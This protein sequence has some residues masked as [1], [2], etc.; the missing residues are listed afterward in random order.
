MF[1][2]LFYKNRY[3]VSRQHRNRAQGEP[4][5]SVVRTW[6]CRRTLYFLCSLC[7]DHHMEQQRR[8][9]GDHQETAHQQRAVEKFHRPAAD[10]WEKVSSSIFT[11]RPVCTQLK[12]VVSHRGASSESWVC[13]GRLQKMESP[14]L[15]QAAA[16]LRMPAAPSLFIA[17]GE[18]GEEEREGVADARA[19]QKWKR[20]GKG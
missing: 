5:I 15:L 17:V 1:V 9:G 11:K 6:W 13:T 16:S 20:F 2:S 18:N 3:I 7:Q 10:W 19:Q 4:S 8:D 12:L 14:R